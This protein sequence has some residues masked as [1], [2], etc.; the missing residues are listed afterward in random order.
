MNE[1]YRDDLAN[2]LNKVR[3]IDKD[4]AKMVLEKESNTE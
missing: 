3:G 1:N 4:A 2:R